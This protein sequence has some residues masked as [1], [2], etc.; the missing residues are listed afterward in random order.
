[1]LRGAAFVLPA[2]GFHAYSATCEIAHI[3]RFK[4]RVFNPPLFEMRES[5]KINNRRGRLTNGLGNRS[6]VRRRKM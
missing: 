3:N 1:M 6:F 4:G 5:L 2:W